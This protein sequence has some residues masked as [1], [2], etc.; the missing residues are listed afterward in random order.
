MTQK[1]A[2]TVKAALL[3]PPTAWAALLAMLSLCCTCPSADA[4]D[5]DVGGT[6]NKQMSVSGA[7]KRQSAVNGAYVL[8]GTTA[9]GRDYYLN[10]AGQYLY[11]DSDCSGGAKTWRYPAKWLISDT[12]P[13]TTATT[14]LAG[15]GRTCLSNA[16]KATSAKTLPAGASVWRMFC[17]EITMVDSGLSV[18]DMAAYGGACLN[19]AY[20]ATTAET[21]PQLTHAVWL[22][23]CSENTVVDTLLS[24]S[25]PT[26]ICKLGYSGDDC[27][28][29]TTTQTAT[30]PTT[31]TT[32]TTTTTATTTTATTTPTTTAT[33]TTTV[34]AAA[35]EVGKS[36]TLIVVVILTALI[37]ILGVVELMHCNTRKSRLGSALH[38]KIGATDDV[39]E[40]EPFLMQPLS[41]GSDDDDAVSRIIDYNPN[42]P[43]G[44]E[45]SNLTTDP[46]TPPPLNNF[47]QIK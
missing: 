31:T 4:V 30:T 21:L 43:L 3:V 22:E 13:S 23:F 15:D 27:A 10:G 33:T 42:F 18:S 39:H 45:I 2:T 38:V 20:M 44:N 1:A 41:V 16:Y 8:Q 24:F 19:N 25:A 47:N 28:I 12:K 40:T 14:D 6:L 36:T 29:Y 32:T 37:S 9:G 11:Y 26:C 5:C 7:C 35:A 46:P 17:A 34:V